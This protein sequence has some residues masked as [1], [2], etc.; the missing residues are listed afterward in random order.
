M[1]PIG[2]AVVGDLR[3]MSMT[4]QLNE[5]VRI[6]QRNSFVLID[7]QYFVTFSDIFDLRAPPSDE[8]DS[9]RTELKYLNEKAE[10]EEAA[11][12]EATR[13]IA[14]EKAAAEKEATMAAA[15]MSIVG[16][17]IGIGLTAAFLW[18]RMK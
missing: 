1:D 5:L 12:I 18:M 9:L 3:P 13:L 11:C 16:V 8:V 17:D 14:A 15:T 10:A 2:R 4:V 6:L 7:D